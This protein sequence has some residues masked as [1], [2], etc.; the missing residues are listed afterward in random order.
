MSVFRSS[1]CFLLCGLGAALAAEVEVAVGA[2]PAGKGIILSHELTVESGPEVVSQGVVSRAGGADVLTSNPS[3]VSVPSGAVVR[4]VVRVLAEDE[5]LSFGADF[6]DAGFTTEQ[7]G[8]VPQR[9]R[10]TALPT[11]GTLLFTGVGLVREV[12]LEIPRDRLVGLR[13]V[14]A[15][16]YHGADAG[17]AFTAAGTG[18]V[19]AERA[20]FFRLAVSEVNDGPDGQGDVVERL[21][22]EIV[23]IPVQTLL[24]NDGDL[25]G[26]LPLSLVDVSY[27]GRNGA[28]VE[29]VGD[30]VVFD[31]RGHPGRDSFS[32][33][34]RDA[35][36]AVTSRVPVKVLVLIGER[37]GTV[38]S[39]VKDENGSATFR[40]T[41]LAH[42]VY[43]I[44]AADDLEQNWYDLPGG[45]IQADAG[46][47]LEFVDRGPLPRTRI[48]RA[49]H[50]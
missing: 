23:R 41:G 12:P 45:F 24:F 4:E 16:N 17:F 5:S 31:P 22:S 37:E 44:Q 42:R 48:Y 2:L 43:R 49:V 10:I 8:E 3:V 9:I 27:T 15:V 14:P 32:Y 40:A 46:G 39:V 34:V 7:V 11:H 19:F 50:P 6:F 36:G 47:R 33:S 26:D 13:F 1:L 18:G 28:A 30:F 25:E 35:R 38:T 29:L 21:A 20:S